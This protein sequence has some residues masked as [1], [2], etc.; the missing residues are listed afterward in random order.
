MFRCPST[1]EGNGSNKDQRDVSP[2][3]LAVAR[4]VDA[5]IKNDLVDIPLV[6]DFIEKR[7]YSSILNEILDRVERFTN[8]SNICFL[9]HF[10]KINIDPV[11]GLAGNLCQSKEEEGQEEG[12]EEKERDALVDHLTQVFFDANVTS[13]NEILLE[14]IITD[15]LEKGFYRNVLRMC[16][17]LLHD[18]LRKSSIDFLGYHITPSIELMGNVFRS[19]PS[20][21]ELSPKTDDDRERTQGIIDDLVEN[22]MHKN[23]NGRGSFDAMSLV[24]NFIERYLYTRAFGVIMAMLDECIATLRVSILH[25]RLSFDFTPA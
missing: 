3:D 23:G 6:P 16:I 15:Y 13:R 25:H 21:S 22:I 7:I 20:E 24:P 18:T 12:Q 4:L 10:L 17:G 9:G 1:K 14:G 2:R 8:D 5:Y 11:C 19:T